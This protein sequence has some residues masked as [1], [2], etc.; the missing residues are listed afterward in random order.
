MPSAKTMI[1]WNDLLPYAKTLQTEAGSL[2]FYDTEIAPS[3]L[4]IVCIHGLGDEADSFRHLF[5]ILKQYYRVIALDLPGFGR[6]N[7]HK[8]AV[9]KNHVK[10]VEAILAVIKGP[11]VLIGSS[12]GA[13]I[14]E[15]AAVQNPKLVKALILMDGALPAKTKPNPGVLIMA[16]PFIGKSWYKAFRKNYDAAYQSLA[17]FYADLEALPQEDKDF[18]RQRVIDRVESETQFKAYFSSLRS[19]IG[20]SV[21]SSSSLEKKIRQF[22]GNILIIW[23]ENDTQMPIET[24]E[25]LLSIRPDAKFA[26]FPNTGHLPHQ[27]KPNDTADTILQFV[28]NIQQNHS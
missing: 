2:F 28:R 22:P 17:P 10:A 9:I 16:A 1:P 27:E 21:F 24:P 13:I 5:P 18:L 15:T 12:M 8:K 26:S 11:V 3:E 7:V 25:Y 20:Y 19:L 14:A 6:S 23:G 4:T